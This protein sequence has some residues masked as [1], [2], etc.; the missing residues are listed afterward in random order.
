[1]QKPLFEVFEKEFSIRDLILLAGG[2]FLLIKTTSEVHGKLEQE[3]N[4]GTHKKLSMRSA[5]I[6]IVLLDVVFSFDSIFVSNGKDSNQ[7]EVVPTK[8]FSTFPTIVFKAE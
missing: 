4:H 3:S 5:I 2:L 8:A 6:Q 1:M 7:P